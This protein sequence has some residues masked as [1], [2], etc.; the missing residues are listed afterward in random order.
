MGYSVV[1]TELYGIQKW[2]EINF[3]PFGYLLAEDS[4]SA[5]RDMLDI[6]SF[7]QYKYDEEVKIKMTT[8]YLNVTSPFIGKYD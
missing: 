4:M 6:T 3:Q 1:Y 7:G 2:S 8:R 5:H